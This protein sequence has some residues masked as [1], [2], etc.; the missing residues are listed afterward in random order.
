MWIFFLTTSQYI[1]HST[2]T[3]GMESIKLKLIA[4]MKIVDAE[5]LLND[6]KSTISANHF[7]CSLSK[8][9]NT[10]S[11]EIYYWTNERTRF[12]L[13]IVLSWNILYNKMTHETILIPF[14]AST[15]HTECI[16]F[17]LFNLFSSIQWLSLFHSCVA[18]RL[19][20]FFVSNNFVVFFFHQQTTITIYP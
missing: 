8:W 15:T 14:G 11:F 2:Q 18:I 1:E 3:N 4:W 19:S 13:R 17:A 7:L 5:P 9:M 10:V 12:K 6:F 16:S 20:G